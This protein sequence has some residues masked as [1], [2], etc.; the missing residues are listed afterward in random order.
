MGVLTPDVFTPRL[1]SL[2][3]LRQLFRQLV[4]LARVLDR[5]LRLLMR[6]QVV[7]L[8]VRSGRRLVTVNAGGLSEGRYTDAERGP[9]HPPRREPL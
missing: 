5:Q 3:L 7:V 9:L 8:R 1:A 2:Q 4:R 6:C